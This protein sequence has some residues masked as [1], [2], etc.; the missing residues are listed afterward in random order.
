MKWADVEKT[1]DLGDEKIHTVTI[2][3]DLGIEPRQGRAGDYWAI[4]VTEQGRQAELT[5]GKRLRSR[6]A[7]LELKKPT[8][9]TIRRTGEGFQTDYEVSVA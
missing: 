5:M 6:I 8:E 9:I 2:R 7:N 4:I 3:P 1:V